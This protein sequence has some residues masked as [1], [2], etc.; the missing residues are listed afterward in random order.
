MSTGDELSIGF[1][2]VLVLVP[3]PSDYG[4][5]TPSIMPEDC[6]PAVVTPEL[7]SAVWEF[8]AAGAVDALVVSMF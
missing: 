4:G 1:S 2:M 3:P 7:S 8:S 5:A 6:S